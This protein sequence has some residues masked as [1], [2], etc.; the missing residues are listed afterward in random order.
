MTPAELLIVARRR[1]RRLKVVRLA[2]HWVWVALLLVVALLLLDR[3]LPW[4]WLQVAAL[5]VPVSSTVLILVV[6]WSRPVSDLEV[7]RALDQGLAS[8]DALSADLEF[9]ADSG[10][11]GSF[12]ERI[13]ERARSVAAGADARTG[14]PGPGVPGRPATLGAV[15]LL[16][17]AALLWVP[18]PQDAARERERAAATATE[19]A[20]DALREAAEQFPSGSRAADSL[21]RA[22]S[23]LDATRP[24]DALSD[25]A[26]A[27]AELTRGAG[28]DLQAARA[29]TDGL[30]R[31]LAAKP[32]AGAGTQ[33]AAE[34][35]RAAS[36]A[37][38]D[39]GSPARSELAD[40]LEALVSTQVAG[41]PGVADT[42]RDASEA[43]AAGDPG[44]AAALEAAA[45]A[46][47]QQTADVAERSDAAGAAAAIGAA[48]ESMAS[49]LGR[50]AA[51]GDAG[52]GGARAG[53]RGGEGEGQG[54]GTA[55]ARASGQG[56]GKGNGEGRGPG[57][58]GRQGGGRRVRVGLGRR[59]FRHRQRNGWGRAGRDRRD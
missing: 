8:R 21:L 35:L 2:W 28:A 45:Q 39:L 3:V 50:A 57:E 54:Q 22:A 25:L 18:N 46:H 55:R 27:Q 44:A 1:F 7:A 49:Q 32:L 5:V 37:V 58:R 19:R 56:Q 33:T 38:D 42:L 20:Q 43:V 34:Q 31:S 47:D 41:A 11:H 24:D 40:R 12:A 17:V 15:A 14:L 48:R 30:E 36:A 29:A 59:P 10:H 52:K 9:G 51:P 26:A 6:V 53:D 23:S 13:S 16:A 4:S